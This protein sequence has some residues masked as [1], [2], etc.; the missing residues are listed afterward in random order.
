MWRHLVCHKSSCN[1]PKVCG[2]VKVHIREL[3]SPSAGWVERAWQPITMTT[4]E[5]GSPEVDNVFVCS[6]SALGWPG[7]G[8]TRLCEVFK[9]YVFFYS[10]CSV[11]NGSV[12]E[13]WQ[14]HSGWSQLPLPQ[15]S[16]PASQ[17]F[18]VVKKGLVPRLSLTCSMGKWAWVWELLVTK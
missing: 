3:F 18:V 6:C 8:D 11:S 7:D 1:H 16:G 9:M 2:F 14:V 5:M 12:P 15:V 13:V 10:P 17:H 4:P